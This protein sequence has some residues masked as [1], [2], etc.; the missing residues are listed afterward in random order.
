MIWLESFAPNCRLTHDSN[1]SPTC[2]STDRINAI[3]TI[4]TL[5]NDPNGLAIM[6]ATTM[7]PIVPVTAPDHV[8]FGLTAGSNFGPPKARPAK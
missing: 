3:M 6:G 2:A 7:A 4:A 8:F 1:K 5:L